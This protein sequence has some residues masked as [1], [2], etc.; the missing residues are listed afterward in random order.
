M[1]LKVDMHSRVPIYTQIRERIKHMVATGELKPGD[2]LPTVRQLAQDLR[3]NLNTVARS[4]TLLNEDGVIS[5]Q[6]GRGTYVRERP[7]ERALS[8]M[9]A[10]KLN[11][12]ATHTVIEAFSLGYKPDEIRAAFN[13]AIKQ[14]E[15]ESKR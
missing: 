4:Y 7:D 5:T 6:Q 1:N 10:E 8:R 15:N 13:T 2:Q 3:V 14:V 12:L 9:R 11:T